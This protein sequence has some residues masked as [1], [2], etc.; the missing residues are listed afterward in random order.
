MGYVQICILLGWKRDSLT[1]EVSDAK[2]ASLSMVRPGDK[3]DWRFGKIEAPCFAVERGLE[4]CGMKA[5]E[6]DPRH[7][8]MPWWSALK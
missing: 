6:P 7:E 2:P 3:P 4:V 1:T 8:F 5:G